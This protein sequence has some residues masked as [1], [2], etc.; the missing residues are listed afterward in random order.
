MQEIIRRVFRGETSLESPSP[1]PWVS[2][3]S[4]RHKVTFLCSTLILVTTGMCTNGI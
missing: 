4:R 2:N 1:R 3:G